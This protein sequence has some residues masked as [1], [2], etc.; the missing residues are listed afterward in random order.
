MYNLADKVG[1]PLKEFP[2]YIEELKDKIDVLRKEIN[3]AEKK[4]R[5]SRRK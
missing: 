4:K 5:L 2:S 1:V 3:Q